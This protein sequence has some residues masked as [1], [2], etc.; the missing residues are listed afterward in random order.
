MVRSYAQSEAL[1]WTQRRDHFQATVK[2]RTRQLRWLGDVSIERHLGKEPTS[3]EIRLDLS[4][5]GDESELLQAA[6]A[7]LVECLKSAC[8]SAT[9]RQGPAGRVLLWPVIDEGLLSDHLQAADQAVQTAVDDARIAHHQRQQDAENLRSAAV[10]AI[11][12]ARDALP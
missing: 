8:E 10:R 5:D 7:A 9:I 4:P 2:Q 1:E 11:A 12:E 3:V 6:G